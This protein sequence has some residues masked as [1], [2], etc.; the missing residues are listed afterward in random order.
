MFSVCYIDWCLL[1]GSLLFGVGWGVVGF[2]LGFV[3]VVLG[4]GEFKVLVFVVVMLVGMVGFEVFER[5]VKL[6][7]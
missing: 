5:W 6:G 3:F 4:M 7:V 2:C 1:L